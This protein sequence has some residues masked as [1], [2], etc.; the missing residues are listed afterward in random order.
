VI[1]TVAPCDIQEAGIVEQRVRATLKAFLHPLSG[2]P[3]GT[4][5]PFG[6]DVYLSDLAAMLEALEGVDYVKELSFSIGGT[7]QGEHVPVPTNRLVAAGTIHI[8]LSAPESS[9]R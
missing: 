5:W 2:G 4:G 9:E 6:R 8:R 7:N 3:D 1:T